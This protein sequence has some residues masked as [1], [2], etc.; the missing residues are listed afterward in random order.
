MNLIKLFFFTAVT[1]TVIFTTS[2]RSS[3]ANAGSSA[4]NYPVA[5]GAPESPM[6]FNDITA[7][8]IVAGIKIGWNLGNT[9]DAIGDKNGFS[10]LGGG[11]YAGTSVQQMETA[12]GNPV[13]VKENFTALKEA[14]FNAVRIPVSW[15]KAV[16][17][18]YNIRPDWMAR[19]AEVVNYAVDNGLYIILNTHHDEEIFKFTN[20]QA[21][22]SLLIFKKIWE[23][24]AAAFRN[25][26]EKLLFEALNEPRTKGALY[27]WTGG[28]AFEHVNLNKF[29]QQFAETVRASGGNN[30][31]R[32]LIVNSYAASAAQIAMSALVIPK[33]SVPNKI[34]ASVH[35]YVP[36]D[37]AL[38]ANSPINTWSKDNNSDTSPITDFIDR[39]YDTF[40]SKGIPVILG[41]FGAMNKDNAGVRAEWAEFYVKYAI[42]KGMPC[43]W[44]DNGVFTG[45]QN[46]EKF[47]LIDRRNNSFPFPQVID[48]LMRG[49][50]GWQPR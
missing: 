34:A 23:Q 46:V 26:D 14:G 38:N 25:Y 24:I 11:R 8:E 6:P 19:I 44:W 1:M 21:E 47:G 37:F 10:W 9:F 41:E 20:A 42:S 39:A 22:E 13:T 7:S 18:E 31:K 16:D 5:P 17:S 4:V 40:V 50:S 27:E 35:A 15:S 43:F 29:Y 2:C 3:S 49:V 36:Y 45:G 30:D 12:W 32:I 48:G 28:I 33:D